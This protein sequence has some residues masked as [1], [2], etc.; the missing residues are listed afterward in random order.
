MGAFI[1]KI[2]KEAK[3]TLYHGSDTKFDQFDLTK[4]GT[5]EGSDLFGRGIYLTSDEGVADFYATH[6]A[7]QKH[8]VG[9]YKGIFDTDVPIYDESKP[10]DKHINT[11]ELDGKVFDIE[12]YI[13]D[14]N[15]KN[16]ITEACLKYPF[17][18]TPDLSQ[19]SLARTFAFLRS[20]GAKQKIRHYR[21]E[22]MYIISQTGE[23]KLTAAIVEY[24]KAMGYDAIKYPSDPSFEKKNGSYNY[25]VMNPKVIKPVK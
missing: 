3:I 14:E 15:F 24:I 9:H 19:Q 12:N 25:F 21:G 5:G 22:L 13:I 20:E 6:K 8:I 10:L 18:G 23:P 1:D 16:Y 17:F 4:M 2:L 7:K 11:F